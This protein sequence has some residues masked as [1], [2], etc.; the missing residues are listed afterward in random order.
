[1]HNHEVT[2]KPTRHHRIRELIARSRVESQDRLQLLLQEEGIEVTQATLSRDLR[3]LGVLKGP[4]GYVLAGAT[5]AEPAGN[6]EGLRRA[7]ATFAISIR[8]GGTLVILRTG[9]GQASALALELDR[10]AMP[11]VL[12]TVAGDDTVFVASETAPDAGRIC[13][14]LTRLAQGT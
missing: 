10:S 8:A 12:G 1:M 2:A 4:Q 14:E 3:E 5:R 13:R 7:L 11:G 6:I 9:P